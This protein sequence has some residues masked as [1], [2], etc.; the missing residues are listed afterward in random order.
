M[1]APN[2]VFNFKLNITIQN[3]AKKVCMQSTQGR[4]DIYMGSGGCVVERKAP[5]NVWCAWSTGDGLSAITEP[6]EHEDSYHRDL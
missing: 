6:N 2:Y 3:W 1:I 5:N 4:S